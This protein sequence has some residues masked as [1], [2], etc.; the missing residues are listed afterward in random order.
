MTPTLL[1]LGAAVGA[2]VPAPA[3]RSPRDAHAASTHGVAE[4]G[5]GVLALPDATDCSVPGRRC[6]TGD[7]SLAFAARPMLRH[8]AIAAGAGLTLGMTSSSDARRRAPTEVPRDHARR[9]FAVEAG[10]RLYFPLARSL[11]GWVGVSSG[12]G[13]VRD[14]F[15]PPSL[16]TERAI[17]GPRGVVLLTEGLTAG[18]G[19]GLAQ[20]VTERVGVGAGVR[21]SSWFLPTD[22]RRGAVGD[23]ASLGG[24]VTTLELV[25]T[26]AYRSRLG[27]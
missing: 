24:R 6:E 18:L 3:P 13:V 25:L 21:A 5:A 4:F 27:F 20:E 17:V 11:E 16:G 23:E 22:R 15:E 7:A 26:L 2:A 14:S 10:A 8:G 19:A 9:Y 1:L 12:L